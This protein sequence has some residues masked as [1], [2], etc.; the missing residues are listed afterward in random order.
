MDGVRE[1]IHHPDAVE[2][3]NHYL[4]A[5]WVE[6]HT[7]GI[8]LELLIDLKVEAEGRTVAPD[9]DGAVRRAGSNEVLLDADIHARDGPRVEWMNQVLVDGVNIL[10]V[11]QVD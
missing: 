6:R 8:V 9:L 3:T 5:G 4:E 1:D 2:E 7:H 11:M 10:R